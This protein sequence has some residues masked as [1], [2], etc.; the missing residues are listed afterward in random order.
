MR[1]RTQFIMT[2]LV[3]GV[4]LVAISISAIITNR[5]V[6]RATLQDRLAHSIV[7]GAGELSYLANDYVI[8]REGQQLDRWQARFSSFSRDVATLQVG[9][10]EQ[11]ALVRN[12]Q[13]NTQRLGDVFVGMV[14]S[15]ASQG[16][17]EPLDLAWVQVS[18]SRMSV[19]SQALVSD[20]SR[21]SQLLSSQVDRM[22]R[23]SFGAV[24]ALIGVL[25]AYFVVTYVM[26]QRR[27][28]RSLATLQAGTA[29]IGSGNLEF[30][31][32]EKSNDEIGDL[33]RDFNRMTQNLQAAEAAL[34]KG[35]RLTVAGKMAASL[36]HEI[37]NPL[38]AVIGCLG[39]AQEAVESGQDPEKYL[40]IAQ[41]E[42]QR[43]ARIV[44]H[45]RSLGRPVQDG[46]K[47][48]T[49][50]NSMLDDVL[51]LNKKH[52]RS[53]KV[54]VDWEPG[55]G[56]P[57]VAVIPDAMRQV[58]LNLVLNAIEAMPKG[59]KLR[60]STA[61][62]NSPACVRVVV[63]DSGMGIAPNVLP[64]IFDAF[65]STK[66]EGMGV[67]LYLCQGIVQQHGGEIE[68]ASQPGVGTT[69]SVWLPAGE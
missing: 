18:W 55:A 14:S 29:V 45:L 22:R 33:S 39:L 46:H 63:A 11:D 36:A 67:G 27:M 13:A 64:R 4:V 7:Q 25:G 17:G 52:L 15:R 56:L 60:L 65:Y 40:Q 62:C 24:L 37:N 66:R 16:P 34:L 3:F 58:F 28:L 30:R 35:E 59:G 31:L 2:M 20:A 5:L 8:Y 38:Q 41:Q 54:E 6:D 26:I 32:E 42:V 43:A 61:Y 1:I 68:V 69:F 53:H 51:M 9:D 57:L 10:P 12:I 48:P 44:T 21:L 23:T 19:Q 50:L 47:E 49:D